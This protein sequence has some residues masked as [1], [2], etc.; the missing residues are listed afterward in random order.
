MPSP[1]SILHSQTFVKK[2]KN[3]STKLY[4][5][6]AVQK[7]SWDS[8][9][10]ALHHTDQQLPLICEIEDKNDT[11]LTNDG[12][13]LKKI[14]YYK[15]R[16]TCYARHFW[17]EVIGTSFLLLNISA[18]IQDPAKGKQVLTFMPPNWKELGDKALQV[19]TSLSFATR[20]FH[21]NPQAAADFAIIE[22]EP[23][24]QE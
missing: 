19:Q 18:D 20:L 23:Y 6:T 13:R 8:K 22:W 15:A 1:F 9:L 16:I 17:E 3:V 21:L 24:N 7:N 11:G 4:S 2:N 14:N 10:N 12:E 5:S